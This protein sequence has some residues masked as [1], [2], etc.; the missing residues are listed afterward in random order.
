MKL[1]NLSNLEVISLTEAATELFRLNK[2]KDRKFVE[3]YIG[4]GIHRSGYYGTYNPNTD[5]TVA[6]SQLVFNQSSDVNLLIEG[7]VR[8]SSVPVNNGAGDIVYWGNGLLELEDGTVIYG[9]AT[10]GAFWGSISGTLTSL[11]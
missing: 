9:G 2:Y 5:D 8:V 6:T 10:A 4:L 3:N 1:G 11:Y 7:Y